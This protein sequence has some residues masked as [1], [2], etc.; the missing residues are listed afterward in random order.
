MRAGHQRHHHLLGL[1][2][3]RAE[4][5]AQRPIHRGA[6]L[7][8]GGGHSCALRTDGTITCWGWNRDGQSDAPS[9][10]YTAV[11]AGSVHSCA[12]RT[13][14]TITCWGWNEYGQS[15][16]AQ[17]PQYTAIAAGS[18]HSCALRTD[19]TITCWG[20]NKWG[21]SDAPSGTI[22]RHRRRRLDFVRAA[23]RRHHHLLGPQRSTAG[24]PDAPSGQYTAIS[25]GNQYSRARL[26]QRRASPA[27]GFSVPVRIILPVD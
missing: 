4:R 19:G 26:Y 11:S 23:H 22:H 20:Y 16:R 18:E 5:R 25:A 15:R 3:V 10:Q 17:R 1:E 8:S 9:G 2:R 24:R 14:G 21:Q 27:G 13:D 7:R 12:L 6:S